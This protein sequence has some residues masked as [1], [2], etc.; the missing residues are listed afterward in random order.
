[1][2]SG[3]KLYKTNSSGLHKCLDAQAGLLKTTTVTALKSGQD[4]FTNGQLVCDCLIRFCF[5]GFL[6]GAKLYF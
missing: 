3:T 6:H 1:M 5:C 4:D 2:K